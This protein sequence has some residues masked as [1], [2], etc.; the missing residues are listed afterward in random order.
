VEIVEEQAEEE[1]SSILAITKDLSQHGSHGTGNVIGF[2]SR[3]YERF[4]D[5]P[6][7]AEALN[8]LGA[9][10]TRNAITFLSGTTVDAA[11]KTLSW[12][13]PTYNHFKDS[14]SGALPADIGTPVVTA[15]ELFGPTD[16]ILHTTEFASK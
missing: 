11:D 9:L 4:P 10:G 8:S 16:F 1:R 6:Q 2:T 14:L 12:T 5:N 13:S 3:L 7:I 15:A